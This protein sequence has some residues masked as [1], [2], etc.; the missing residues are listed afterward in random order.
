MIIYELPFYSLT[1]SI[2]RF[3][4]R[5][6]SMRLFFMLLL[7]FLTTLTSSCSPQK[8]VITPA[9]TTFR[10]IR[11]G[12]LYGATTYVVIQD[13]KNATGFDYELAKMFAETIGAHLTIKVF[14]NIGELF[15]ALEQHDIDFIA[16]GITATTAR[17][18]NFIFSPPLY[19]VKQQLVYKTHKTKR[20]RQYKDIKDGLLVVADSAYIDT[21]NRAKAKNPDLTWTTTDEHSLEELL[22]MVINEKIKYTVA[23]STTLAVNRRYAPDLGIGFSMTK[24]E[25]VAWVLSQENSDELLSQ[26]LDFWQQAQASGTLDLL[27]EKY[28]GH[29]AKFDFVDTKAFIKAVKKKLPRYKSTFQKHAGKLDWRKVAATS[30]QESHWNPKARSPTGVRV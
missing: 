3:K 7:I 4:I 6:T 18:K 13:H 2:Q 28:F 8:E 14:D 20:P 19:Q 25:N 15:A 27:H 5:V 24:K 11:V 16:A 21:L 1:N 22:S 12:T 17:E 10:E 26:M 23:D 29:V 9:V 30:Y